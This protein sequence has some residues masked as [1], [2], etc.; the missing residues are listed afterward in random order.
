MRNPYTI[1]NEVDKMLQLLIDTVNIPSAINPRYKNVILSQVN[2]LN[3]MID[4]LNTSDDFIIEGLEKRVNSLERELSVMHDKYD[5][6]PM[7][8]GEALK[9]AFNE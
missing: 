1:Q 3:E 4:D 5:E 2:T 9:E 8:L 7:T 6:E